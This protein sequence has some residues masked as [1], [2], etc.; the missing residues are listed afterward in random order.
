MIHSAIS[1]EGAEVHV[2]CPCCDG[3]GSRYLSG[4]TWGRWGGSDT[5]YVECPA[6]DGQGT[7]HQDDAET[8]RASG[9]RFNR[10]D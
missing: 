7:V 5:E 10:E 1:R 9:R 8:I 3:E 2:T 6:C 4:P